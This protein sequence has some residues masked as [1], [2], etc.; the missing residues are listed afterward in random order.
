MS[1]EVAVY[2]AEMLKLLGGMANKDDGGGTVT[3]PPT[4]KINYDPDSIHPRGEWVVGQKKDSD[5]G[6]ISDEGKI[7]K[8]LV[9]LVARNRWSYYNQKDTR[10][11]CNSPFYLRGDIVRGSNYG[12]I[13]G[14]TCP[15][16]ADGLQTRCKCQIVLF[17]KAITAEGEFIDCISY[18][19]GAS[20]MP[21]QNYIDSIER[22]KVKG[23]YIDVP[24]FASLTLLGSEKKRNEGTT[25]FVS[26]LKQGPMFK[27]RTQLME[28]NEAREEVY[29]YIARSN[30]AQQENR[31]EP[32]QN[33]QP[34][35][36]VQPATQ[37]PVD[38]T[39]AQQDKD[40]VTVEPI[41]DD[42]VPDFA[43]AITG[44]GN[45][46]PWETEAAAEQPAPPTGQ[47]PPPT[48]P[49]EDFDLLGTINSMLGGNSQ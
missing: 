7:V 48:A 27:D 19:G 30:E 34:P 6:E 38:V 32:V 17:G 20:Y 49:P 14:K 36:S 47:V 24:L 43:K 33:G 39:P 28:F 45:T 1:T 35:Q 18:Q 26:A 9:I 10:A 3:G 22:V 21:V 44:Q 15:M 25:Y 23:G 16:R 4:L 12:N 41:N 40:V 42:T 13:C 31:G 37:V 2:D 11:N 5:T 29:Q 8:G 46:A